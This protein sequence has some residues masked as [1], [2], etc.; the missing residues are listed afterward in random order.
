MPGGPRAKGSK[1]GW[2][3]YA[4][5]TAA[6]VVTAMTTPLFSIIVPT[7]NAAA[8]VQTCIESLVRQTYRDF[9]LVLVDG[10]S[11]DGTCDIANSFVPSLGK[12]L[13]VHCGTDQG[14]YDAIKSRCQ[15]G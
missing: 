2:K 5:S 4:E 14:V 8:S 1:T 9:E 11:R 13:A 12:R 7:L 3:Q 10:G 6:S 15:H